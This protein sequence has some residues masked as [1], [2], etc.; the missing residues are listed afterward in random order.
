M[1]KKYQSK[2]VSS[3]PNPPPPHFLF[4]KNL[5]HSTKEE[6]SVKDYIRQFQGLGSHGEIPLNIS[7]VSKL[8]P[9]E[10]EAPISNENH[11]VYQP[12]TQA[13]LCRVILPLSVHLRNGKPV[14]IHMLQSSF[15]WGCHM[16]PVQTEK[17]LHYLLHCLCRASAAVHIQKGQPS[18]AC[19]FQWEG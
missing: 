16:A 8:T 1:E 19:P 15:D 9:V 12:C 11:L 10:S 2:T 14:G 3:L 5:V 6:I 13:V 17:Y 7:P 4:K 18:R